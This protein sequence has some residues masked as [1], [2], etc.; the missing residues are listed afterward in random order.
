MPEII[1]GIDRRPL[2]AG[3]SLFDYADEVAIAV[4]Q[5]CG[6]SGRCRE[7]VIE[8]RQGGEALS[9]RTEAEAYLPE[10]F[11][12]ACQACGRYH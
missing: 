7:C 12:L 4:P 3:K 9:P 5:S 11:R 8:I 1:H 2:E 6:R 10:D